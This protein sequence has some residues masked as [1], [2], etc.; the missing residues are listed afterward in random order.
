MWHIASHRRNRRP[1]AI[2]LASI[3]AAGIALAATLAV[4]SLQPGARASGDLPDSTILVGTGQGEG[5]SVSKIT[6]VS[7][8]GRISHPEHWER[9]G[10]GEGVVYAQ[11]QGFTTGNNDDGYTISKIVAYVKGV[12][13]G[14]TPQVS[15]YASDSDGNPDNILY[16]LTNPASFSNDAQN[17]FS[18]PPNARLASETDYFVVFENDVVVTSTE[19]YRV[20]FVEGSG[21]DANAA[22]GWTLDTEQEYPIL[23]SI[24]GS[25]DTGY[26]LTR[27]PNSTNSNSA[28]N[29]QATNYIENNVVDK[30][31]DDHAWVRTAWSDHPLPVRVGNYNNPGFYVYSIGGAQGFSGVARGLR[32]GFT[33]SGYKS[34]VVVLH[35]LAHHFVLDH[36]VPDV[37]GA[38]GVGWLYFNHRV[39]G[40]CPVGE[41]Y[42]DLLGYQT[43]RVATDRV[44]Y[45]WNCREIANSNG[46]PDSESI[47]VARS[48]AK[49]EIADWFYEHYDGG[50]G[51]VD[52]DAVWADL[53]VANNKRIATYAMRDMFGGFCSPREA[54]WA[55]GSAGPS[56]GNPWRDGGCHWRKPQDMAIVTHNGSLA[57]T[58]DPHL[59]E[60]GPNVSHYA[61]Q[62]RTADQDFDATRRALVSETADLSH[63]IDGLTDGVE[64]FV[65]VA[66][67]HS[68]SPTVI[69][70]NDGH[71]RW[72]AFSAVPGKPAAPVSLSVTPGDHEIRLTWDEPVHSEIELS[73]YQVDWKTGSQD[74]DESRRLDLAPAATESAVIPGLQN[75]V[76]YTVRVSAVSHDG[77][78]GKP[79]WK[80]V[81][82]AGPPESPTD[83]SAVGGK[84]SLLVYWQRPASGTIHDGYVVQWRT[85]GTY[86]PGNE[87]NVWRP[88]DTQELVRNMAGHGRYYV[89]VLARNFLGRSEPS[90]EVF[91]MSGAPGGLTDVSAEVRPGGG[92]NITWG[93]PDP[94]YPNNPDFRPVRNFGNKR[95]I[96]DADGNTVPQYRY[97]IEYKLADGEPGGWCPQSSYRDVGVGN[98]TLNSDALTLNLTSFCD[99]A[100]PVIGERYNT[101]IRAAYVWHQSGDT[102][103]RNGPWVYSGPVVYDLAGGPPGTPAGIE[104][105]GGKASLLVSWDPPSSGGTVGGYIIQWRTRGTYED[106]DQVIVDDPSAR[107]HLLTGMAGHGRYY[108]RIK[109]F[110]L[111]GESTTT[112]DYF[113]MSGAP[114]APATV[115]AEVRAAGGF[116]VAWDRPDPYYPNNPDFRPVRNFGN[117][118]PIR[119]ADGN[120]VPQYRYD[121]EYKL[122]DGESDG[123]CSQSR[124]RDVGLGNNT[125]SSDVLTVNLTRYCNGAAPVEGERY[126]FR[127]RA[128]YVWHQSGD[129]NPRNGPWAYSGPVVYDPTVYNQN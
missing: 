113:V 78:I 76:F 3:A 37:P 17:T 25:I 59:Y 127:V 71:N 110:N 69:Q 67:V 124:Y 112:G 68:N 88:W 99:D 16:T 62:W 103:P 6:L 10:P 107:S 24:R 36:R 97:D 52:M 49:G 87:V 94:Y 82:P 80:T 120:T 117:K 47:R 15:I 86:E 129:T 40:D 114:R 32:W 33:T 119:D 63:T 9:V 50:D 27:S 109:A 58:W 29:E 21:H 18:A 74:F 42:A 54:N 48:V 19:H 43:H 100:E 14:D 65:R 102:N 2:A 1:I 125:L 72:V 39:K 106:D 111:L 8:L 81:A 116:T 11:A 44:G 30:Y 56:H 121:I 92:F 45:L 83:I 101:R 38:V 7:N 23:V 85:R 79:S 93:R 55:L 20:G 118:R 84:N 46:K 128:A 53:K 126:N 26:E 60:T 31:G 95:P 91:V 123:W 122:A 64:H 75:G 41:I 96:R 77:T 66:A 13:S 108:V 28:R 51:T 61:V 89:R 22:A 115:S 104:A 90:G 5:Q 12:G 35:E 73:G 34:K 105:V 70:D 98:D 4:G 57:V